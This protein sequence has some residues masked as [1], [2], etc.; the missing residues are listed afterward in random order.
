MSASAVDV[1]DAAPSAGPAYAREEGRSNCRVASPSVRAFTLAWLRGSAGIFVANHTVPYTLIGIILSVAT[2]IARS[3]ALAT[4]YNGPCLAPRFGP[5]RRPGQGGA[6]PDRPHT[7]GQPRGPGLAP[8][9]DSLGLG[10]SECR[11]YP[12]L[13]QDKHEF[14]WRTCRYAAMGSP[15]CWL[16]LQR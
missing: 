15:S 2:H 14:S 8:A 3:A 13:R 10:P 4:P 9:R 5:A 6:R 1:P 11:G 16:A 7:R 12:H